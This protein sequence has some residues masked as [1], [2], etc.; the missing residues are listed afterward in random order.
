MALKVLAV[1][2]LHLGRT[3]SRLPDELSLQ[4]RDLGPAGAWHRIVDAALAERVDALVLAG[5]V[6]EEENDF[7]EAWRELAT[8]VERLLVAGIRVIA[9]VGNHNI[10]VL[11]RLADQIVGFELLGRGGAWQQVT[12]ESGGE[13][14]TLHGW[15]FPQRSYG[16]I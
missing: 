6:V 15:S 7:F 12:L 11:P 9:V 5:D 8:G 3:P 16:Q 1:G 10:Q 13:R 2:D 14:L 4:A